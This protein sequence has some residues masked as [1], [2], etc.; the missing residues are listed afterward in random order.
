VQ[1]F[2]VDVKVLRKTFRRLQVLYA[3]RPIFS[4][5]FER[6]SKLRWHLFSLELRRHGSAA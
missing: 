1:V 6:T 2:E 4:R 3:R 5:R